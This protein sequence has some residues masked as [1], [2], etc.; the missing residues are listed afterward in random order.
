MLLIIAPQIGGS[1]S[2]DDDVIAELQVQLSSMS[3]EIAQY[4][5]DINPLRQEN[6]QIPE[7]KARI[8]YLEHLVSDKNKFGNSNAISQLQHESQSNSEEIV[9]LKLALSQQ[10]SIEAHLCED[11]RKLRSTATQHEIICKKIISSCSNVPLEQV[12]ELLQPLM[13]AIDSDSLNLDVNFLSSFMVR[14]K[15]A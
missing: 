9:R 14:L 10:K 11:L 1:R 4:R 7:M 8:S 12:E 3:K 6:E 2:S 13:N 5:K 15:S